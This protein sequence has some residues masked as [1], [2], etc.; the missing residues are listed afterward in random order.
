MSILHRLNQE[1]NKAKK[2]GWSLEGWRHSNSFV[3]S[4][5]L[6]QF[7]NIAIMIASIQKFL[8]PMSQ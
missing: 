7:I 4:K 8:F 5:S 6:I 2:W 3:T 1:E